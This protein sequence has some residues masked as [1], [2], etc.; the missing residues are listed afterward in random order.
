MYWTSQEQTHTNK[1]YWGTFDLWEEKTCD[2][3]LSSTNGRRHWNAESVQGLINI[4]LPPLTDQ[5]AEENVTDRRRWDTRASSLPLTLLIRQY[6]LILVNQRYIHSLIM[7]FIMFSLFYI[8]FSV[9]V[10]HFCLYLICLL[11]FC[12]LLLFYCIVC[13]LF[14]NFSDFLYVIFIVFW[15][16]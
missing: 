14:C 3:W 9:F 4:Q 7:Y 15:V 1:S 16:F 6:F 2:L 5:Q 12:E 8:K 13:I 10:F 11:D